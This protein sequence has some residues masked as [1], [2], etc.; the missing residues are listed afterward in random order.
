MAVVSKADRTLSENW[1]CHL[2]RDWRLQNH[3][4][5]QV[6]AWWYVLYAVLGVLER[7]T[8]RIAR[9]QP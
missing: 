7:E 4:S 6:V 1:M 5:E 2:M 8:V 3:A 9:D